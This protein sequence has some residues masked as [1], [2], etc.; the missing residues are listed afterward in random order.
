MANRRK[1]AEIPK[2]LQGLRALFEVV[3][4]G[5]STWEATF[6]AIRDPVLI[7]NK[8]YQIERA[9]LASSER[10]GVG[11]RE[12]IG[13]H[14]YEIFA[15]RQAICP[16]CPLERTLQSKRPH[17]VEIEKLRREADFQ[18]NSYPLLI[19]ADRLE[20]VHHY[21]D[22]T[23][24]KL[25]QKKL[26]QSEK[27]VAIG[28]LA[29]GVAHEINNPLG[30]IL[31]FTQLLQSEFSD[32]HPAQKD[33]QEIRDAAQRCKK[34]VEDL[35]SFSRPPSGNEMTPQDVKSLLEKI[36]P[37]LRLNLRAAS[38]EIR[39][40]YEEHLPPVLGEANRLQ[41]VFMNLIQ[42]AAEAMKKGGTVTI[43]TS[44]DRDRTECHVEIQDSG[45]GIKKE[46]LARIFDPFFTTKGL[47]GT[48][49]G[50]SIC[51]SIVHDHRGRI[52]V[53]SE[54]GRGALFRVVLP[55]PPAEE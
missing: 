40:E 22:V 47:K 23:E 49:L 42:N 16:K 18:V 7:I 9:N 32:D 35:L 13:R 34:I 52:E 6:D 55:I 33:L 15:G 41:Q 43:R 4:K 50:L 28:M 26:M 36:L 27:M 8:D 14:C 5:K 51:D 11:V 29:G 45:P 48:G 30:G 44:T 25:L 46:I 53:D 1:A 37:L 21:R 38:V 12:M 54:F 39:T 10:A 19:E 24:E 3:E 20:V 31:A 2:D 17:S